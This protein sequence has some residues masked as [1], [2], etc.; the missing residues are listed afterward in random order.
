MDFGP[1]VHILV[2]RPP[3]KHSKCLIDVAMSSTCMKGL[4]RICMGCHHVATMHGPCSDPRPG[5]TDL[6]DL[7]GTVCMAKSAKKGHAVQN[8]FCRVNG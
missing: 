5:M 1:V 2:A 8:L 3:D 7:G 4:L 6:R